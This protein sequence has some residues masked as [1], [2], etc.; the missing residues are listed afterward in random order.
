M[1]IF[2]CLLTWSEM[3]FFFYF[4]PHSNNIV[5]TCTSEQVLKVATSGLNT[6]TVLQRRVKFCPTLLNIPGISFTTK[7]AASI[8]AS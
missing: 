5:T 4:K 8:L 6:C 3:Y 2:I 7:Q 1:R